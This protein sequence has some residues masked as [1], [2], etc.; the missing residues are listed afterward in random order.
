MLVDHRFGVYGMTRHQRRKASVA[1]KAAKNA[2]IVEAFVAQQRQAIVNR[3][4]RS[5]PERNFYP[6][7][8]MANMLSQS[9]RGYICRA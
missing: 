7:S 9:H 4:L 6:Q 5:K 3:N 8:S 2:A 1:R